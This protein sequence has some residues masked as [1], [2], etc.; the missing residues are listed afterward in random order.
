M[1][2]RGR[3]SGRVSIDRKAYELVQDGVVR[4]SIPIAEVHASAKMKQAINRNKWEMP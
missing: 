1:T 4:Q 2:R 3:I